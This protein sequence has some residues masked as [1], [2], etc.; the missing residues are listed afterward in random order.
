MLVDNLLS[1]LSMRDLALWSLWQLEW[2]HVGVA[3]C[4]LVR[5][6]AVSIERSILQLLLDAILA[7]EVVVSLWGLRHAWLD[8]IL[9]MGLWAEA[10]M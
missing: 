6:A 7:I 8:L 4:I 2:V 9:L 1:D 3:H 10:R 5:R